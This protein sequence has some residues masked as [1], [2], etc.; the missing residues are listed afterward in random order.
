MLLVAV[1]VDAV[2]GDWFIREFPA[3]SR[4]D[5]ARML[6]SRLKRPVLRFLNN[7]SPFAIV[8]KERNEIFTDPYQQM[9]KYVRPFQRFLA[10][11]IYCPVYVGL[12]CYILAPTRILL[13][14]PF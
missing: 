5:A 2:S 14:S 4:L 8:L 12:L 1:D 10:E 6:S 13:K 3:S 11:I 9:T 7:G